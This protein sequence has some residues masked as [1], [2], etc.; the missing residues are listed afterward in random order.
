MLRDPADAVPLCPLPGLG[1][2]DTLL[3]G[4]RAA[5]GTA[6]ARVDA[7]P[8]ELPGPVQAAVYRVVQES[9]ANARRHAPGAP[10]RL[11]VAADRDTGRLLLEVVNGPGTRP[12]AAGAGTGLGVVGM[13]ARADALGGELDAG[14]TADGGFRVLAAVPLETADA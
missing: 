6:E 1:E 5:G 7:G 10:V 2:L 4:H 8:E 9:L 12:G 13:R 3:D 11:T 14:P